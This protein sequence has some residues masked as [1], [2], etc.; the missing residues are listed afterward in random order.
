MIRYTAL[1]LACFAPAFANS[2]DKLDVKTGL[3]E[4]EST[5]Q[6]SG[7]PIPK[8]L[9][10]TL[11]PEQLA[12]MRKELDAEAAKGPTSETTRDCI[13]EEDL[14]DPFKSFN[15]KDCRPTTVTTTGRTQEARMVCEGEFK[16]TG[17]IRINSPTSETMNGTVDIKMSDGTETFTMKGTLK[18]RWISAD[19]GEEGDEEMD[20]DDEEP[21]DD[22]EEDSSP[23]D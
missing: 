5:I 19:C 16:G 4:T 15:R 17:V 22:D 3:W 12:K 23:Q 18:G 11:K 20:Y 10:D 9:R 14:S 2:A 8:S 7:L 1:A 21:S 13:T 6:M